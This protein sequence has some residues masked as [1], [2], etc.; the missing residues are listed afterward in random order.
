MFNTNNVAST[1]N[2]N[3]TMFWSDRSFSNHTSVNP[4]SIKPILSGFIGSSYEKNRIIKRS[5]RSLLFNDLALVSYQDLGP[6]YTLLSVSENGNYG[7]FINLMPATYKVLNLN[8]GAILHTIKSVNKYCA[9]SGNHLL[10]NENE[11]VEKINLITSQKAVLNLKKYHI[12]ES[13]TQFHFLEK[14]SS[15]YVVKTHE[16][17]FKNTNDTVYVWDLFS[18]K[19]IVKFYPE[20]SKNR[21]TFFDIDSVHNEVTFIKRQRTINIRDL[22]TG[23]IK[24]E[25][26]KAKNFIGFVDHQNDQYLISS[27]DGSIYLWDKKNKS[28][29]VRVIQDFDEFVFLTP[30]KYYLTSKEMTDKIHFVREDEIYLFEQ[31]DLKYNRPD[32]ILDRLGYADSS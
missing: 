16:N 8:T 23:K 18:G 31:F 21:Y 2:I 25:F 3:K 7:L 32:I 26:S 20:D 10:I 6:S 28:Y 12:T 22:N 17:S 9:L 5:D 13:Q 15:R 30:E 1:F 24:Y 11:K 27:R 29:T 4:Y 14:S 19:L